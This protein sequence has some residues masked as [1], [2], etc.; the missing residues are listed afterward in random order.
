MLAPHTQAPVCAAQLPTPPALQSALSLQLQTPFWQ[1]NPVGQA[2]PQA[3]QF[4]GSVCTALQPAGLWQHTEFGPHPGPSLHE[5]AVAVGPVDL[6][7]SP[8][9][10][11]CTPHLQ[12]SV[13]VSQVPLMPQRFAL[14]AHPQVFFVTWPQTSP[15]PAAWL[16]QSLP[17]PPQ[18]VEFCSTPVSQ[19][20][21][22]AGAAG[23]EQL[24]LP[25][26]Q[27]GVQRPLLQTSEAT[28]PVL[29]A[30]P[31]APQ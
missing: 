5:H 11:V 17:Q 1:T 16:L 27:N 29:H 3:P 7:I 18:L 19:P 10:Q 13:A 23:D 9:A 2:C 26:S 4:S 6:Q 21:S 22:L 20:S 14:P 8:C 12:R 30:R 28:P 31:Q 15:L 24:A 25:S